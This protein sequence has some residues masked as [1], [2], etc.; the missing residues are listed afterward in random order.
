[1]RAK[2]CVRLTRRPLTGFWYRAVSLQHWKTRLNSSHSA[3]HPSRFSA[4]TLHS[5]Q[6][7]VVYFGE[8]HQVAVIEVGALLGNPSS[9]VANPKGSWAIM[10]FKI[11]L[12][13][14]VDLTD[15]TS[16]R[17]IHTNYAE[18]TGNWSNFPGVAPTQELGHELFKLPDLEGFLYD[19]SKA[20]AKCLALFPTKLGPGSTV[21]FF[22][23]MTSKTERLN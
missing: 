16:Q 6:H 10:S 21:T 23:E 11:I 13:N 5:P 20:Q 14:I 9:P 2:A 15:T 18:L 12:N 17:T 1:M 3:T 7:R 22:N 4:A 19:S 8:N